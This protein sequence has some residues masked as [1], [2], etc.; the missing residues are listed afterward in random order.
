[1]TKNNK[2]FPRDKSHR[3]STGFINP[4]AI[5][6]LTLNTPFFY[7]A[8]VLGSVCSGFGVSVVVV[9]VRS[10]PLL[11]GSMLRR[12]CGLLAEGGWATFVGLAGSAYSI[13]RELGGLLVGKSIFKNHDMK[14][15]VFSRSN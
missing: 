14:I 13:P 2:P 15:S 12:S 9:F 3:S 8:G 11:R 10:I 6:N 1:M 4:W 5:K 7:P